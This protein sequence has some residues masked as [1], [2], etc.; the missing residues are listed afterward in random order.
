MHPRL[1]ELSSF[2]TAQR[3]ALLSAAS[4]VPRARWS[5]PPAEGRW[6]VAQVLDHLYRVETGTARLLA[7]RVTAARAAGHP[8]ETETSSVLHAFDGRGLDDRSAPFEAPEIVRPDANAD[9]ATTLASLQE[10]RASMLESIRLADGLA[11]GSIKHTHLR[12]GEIDLYQWILF[13]GLHE[14]RHAHQLAEV[15]GQ[16][17]SA[18]R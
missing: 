1:A 11:L 15:A 8:L 17:N 9:A 4:S 6:S 5:E 16:L 10:S 12:F 3:E 14:K 7:K 2:L 18:T 13:V